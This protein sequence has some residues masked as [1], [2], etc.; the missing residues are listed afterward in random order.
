MKKYNKLIGG[1]NMNTSFLSG[2]SGSIIMI[3]LGIIALMYP[4]V[5]TGA[6]GFISGLAFILLAAAFLVRG[7]EELI[8]TKYFGLIYIIFAI[9][10]VL[11]AYYFIFDP[12]FVSGFIGFSVYLFG[13][14]LVILG[15]VTFFAGPLGIM[16]A[17][18][19][20]YGF[21]TLI[22]AVFINDPKILG[23]LVGLWLLISG[24]VSLFTD[25][26]DYIDV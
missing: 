1:K 9:L 8:I 25:N 2:K 26:R 15:I 7:I 14:L 10:S 24:I 19:L 13:I 23:T 21:L 11:V 17:I 16:G 20:I 22:L 18:T 6:I 3:I 12:A 4:M 5:S